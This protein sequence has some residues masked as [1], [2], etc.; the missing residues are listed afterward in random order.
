ME[1]GLTWRPRECGD[2]MGNAGPCVLGALLT[3]VQIS[4]RCLAPGFNDLNKL[5]KV[6]VCGGGGAAESMHIYNIYI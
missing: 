2:I 1:L 3:R 6:C 4:K 5:S